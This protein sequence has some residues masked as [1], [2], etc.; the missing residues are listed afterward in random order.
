MVDRRM[1]PVAE[2]ISP[3]STGRQPRGIRRLSE[4]RS[5]IDRLLRLLLYVVLTLV[6]IG[7]LVPSYWMI[8]TSLKPTG[9]ELT[10]PI[11]WWPRRI[12]WQNYVKVLQPQYFPYF[13]Y[14]RNTL[15]ITVT[16]VVASI[17]AASMVA[18]SL[19]RLRWRGR[20]FVFAVCISTMMLPGIVTMIPTFVIFKKLGWMNTFLPLVVPTWFGGGAFN[21]FLLRQFFRTLPMD[22]DEA[23]R[24]DGASAFGIWIMI[25]LPLAKPALATVAIFTFLGNWNNFM[26][27][28]LYL[29]DR[30]LFPISLGLNMLN[31]SYMGAGWGVPLVNLIMAATLLTVLPVIIVFF[32][33]QRYFVQGVVMSGLAA[34]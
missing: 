3:L 19:S 22:L 11:E 34:R 32:I 16:N 9:T 5:F 28:L 30:Q 14:L 18:Y 20:E 13:L 31:A 15:I 23:A 10:R 33:G 29:S 2:E 17:L 26:G 7:L 12:V 24:I 21:I 4:S 6:L 1:V 8:I 25:I 27:P